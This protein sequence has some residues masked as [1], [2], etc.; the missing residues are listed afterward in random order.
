MNWDRGFK[1]LYIALTVLFF[2]ALV[3]FNMF[4]IRT[5]KVPCTKETDLNLCYNRFYEEA[6]VKTDISKPG[7]TT[8]VPL[9]FSERLPETLQNIGVG[10]GVWALITALWFLIRWVLLG[11]KKTASARNGPEGPEE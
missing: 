1:R 9:T 7:W 2:I 10:T 11:F 6:T 5:K 3:A 4:D 8:R